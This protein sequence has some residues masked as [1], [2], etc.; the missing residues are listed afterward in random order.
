MSELEEVMELLDREADASWDVEVEPCPF[1]KMANCNHKPTPEPAESEWIAMCPQCGRGVCV[2]C[3]HWRD[4][5]T[6]LETN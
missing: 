6:N 2:G 3:N 5:A 4:D 1:C